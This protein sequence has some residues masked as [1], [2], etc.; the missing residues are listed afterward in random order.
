LEDGFIAEPVTVDVGAGQSV[1]VISSAALGSTSPGGADRLSLFIGYQ[2][3]AGGVITP[4][5][6]GESGLT[7]PQ[8]QYG[9]GAFTLGTLISESDGLKAGQYKVG[10]AGST[11]DTHWDWTGDSNTTALVLS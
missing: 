10:L 11:T 9:R 6:Y 2:P 4:V 7:S 5:G 3:V 8:E 1:L